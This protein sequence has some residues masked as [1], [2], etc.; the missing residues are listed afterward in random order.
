MKI[1]YAYLDNLFLSEIDLYRAHRVTAAQAD[2]W[3]LPDDLPGALF[4]INGNWITA[5]ET[6]ALAA[7]RAEGGRSLDMLTRAQCGR[8]YVTALSLDRC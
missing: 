5:D 7:V 6:E 1:A 3:E 8:R 4:R 2:Q